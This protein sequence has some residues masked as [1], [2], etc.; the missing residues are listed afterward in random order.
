MEA[1]WV[2]F[3]PSRQTAPTPN[4]SSLA[5]NA[6]FEFRNE[7]LSDKVDLLADQVAKLVSAIN[8]VNHQQP[9]VGQP[10]SSYALAASQHAPKPTQASSATQ[11]SLRAQPRPSPRAR[12]EASLTLL[13]QDP[14]NISGAGKT[15]TKLI[16][17]LNTVLK[18]ANIKVS[19]SDTSPI[20]VPNIHHH[21]SHDLVVY[22]ESQK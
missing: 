4:P 9:S 14:K 10:K 7:A 17:S 2:V 20:V 1:R 11:L 5:S 18:D 15:I 16:M 3:D 19:Q 22:L 21:P 8:P 6:R 13:Q 12:S